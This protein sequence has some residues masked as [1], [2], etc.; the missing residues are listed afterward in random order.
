MEFF[1]FCWKKVGDAQVARP[2]IPPGENFRNR[3]QSCLPQTHFVMA[4]WSW[5]SFRITESS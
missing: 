2:L 4:V 1:L 5:G 3:Q